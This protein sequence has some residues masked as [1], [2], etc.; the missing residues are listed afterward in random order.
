MTSLKAHQFLNS[1]VNFEI[2]SGNGAGQFF[3][4]QRIENLLKELGDPQKSFK[5]IHVAGSK[6]KGTT[7]AFCAH[8]LEKAGYKVGLYTSPHLKHVNERIRI[9]GK[10]VRGRPK[11]QGIFPDSISDEDLDRL[12]GKYRVILEKFRDS[13]KHGPLTYFEVLTALAFKYFEQ[14]SVDIVVLETGLGGRLDATNMVNPLV[15]GLTPISR[16]HTA[17]LGDT[18]AKIAF[19]KAAIIKI[20]KPVVIAPQTKEAQ[21]VIEGQAHV[22]KAR[23]YWVGEDI[24][25]DFGQTDP[26]QQSFSVTGLHT[27]Y[28]LNTRLLGRHQVVNAA[29][30]IGLVECLETDSLYVAPQAIQSGIEDTFWP[31]RFEVVQKNPWI[32]LDAAHNPQSIR[33]LGDTVRRIFPDKKVFP[34]LGV[35]K[36]KDVRG[37]CESILNMATEIIL[38]RSR[39]PRAYVFEESVKAIFKAIPVHEAFPVPEAVKLALTRAQ[40]DDVIL[41][42]GSIFLAAE[43]REVLLREK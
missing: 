4:L 21:L 38:T 25:F 7:C 22:K 5:S 30:A 37:I 10:D 13:P 42:T 29:V 34:I 15:C 3:Q 11:S 39:N 20:N 23:P 1:F 27:R 19:E 41:I 40:K 16:E 14:Q 24:V 2:Q 12:V 6:G 8:I 32:V 28:Q 33:T 43:A 36:D 17:I 31:C 26:L 35:S 9:L 18:I